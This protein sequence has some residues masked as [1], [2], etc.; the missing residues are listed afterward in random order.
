[1]QPVDAAMP[2]EKFYAWETNIWR[3]RSGGIAVYE[4]FIVGLAGIG[5]LAVTLVYNLSLLKAIYALFSLRHSGLLLAVWA[6]Q[7]ALVEGTSVDHNDCMVVYMVTKDEM[8]RC[9]FIDAPS[10]APAVQTMILEACSQMPPTLA[11]MKP[12]RRVAQPAGHLLAAF[13][14]II[15]V[16]D[17]SLYLMT[18]AVVAWAST[19]CFMLLLIGQGRCICD[20]LLSVS[21][22]TGSLPAL[23]EPLAMPKDANTLGS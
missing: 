13:R 17:T 5:C 1:M 21:W 22:L 2:D 16:R 15:A 14:S 4:G 3:W 9:T 18:S 19:V 23:C 6:L 8:W 10:A 20:S 7:L 11:V 12:L